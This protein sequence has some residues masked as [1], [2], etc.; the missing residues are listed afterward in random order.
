MGCGPARL[1]HRR[2]HVL[3]PHMQPPQR[4]PLCGIVAEVAC[5]RGGTGG[6]DLFQPRQVAGQFGVLA[7]QQ[8]DDGARQG[9]AQ[10]ALAQPEEH[11]VAFLVAGDQ[12]GF[13]HQLQVPADAR[14]ALA[15][16]LGQLADVEF[17]MRKDKEDANPSRLG[18]RPQSCQ[19]F[20]HCIP[21]IRT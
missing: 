10:V 20:V 4:L 2:F 6:A 5:R 16:D 14:L 8:V 7:G 12:A 18:R 9:A 21:L 15:Q 11:P 17:A 19:K 1:Q 13:R 3:L